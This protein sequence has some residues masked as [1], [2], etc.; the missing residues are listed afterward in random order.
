MYEFTE[1]ELP[2]D[3]GSAV[4]ASFEEV[5]ERVLEDTV[6]GV[7][8][9]S[10]TAEGAMGGMETTGSPSSESRQQRPP[11]GIPSLPVRKRKSPSSGPA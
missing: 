6:G 4:E 9:D 10:D 5:T 7:E 11:S 3:G 8:G 2:A 1:A